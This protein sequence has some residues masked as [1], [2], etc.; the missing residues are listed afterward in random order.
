M[1]A[2]RSKLIQFLRDD[3]AV[4]TPAIDFALR[5]SP[6][7]TPLPM[8]LWQYGLITLSQLDQIFDWLEKA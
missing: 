6:L 5:Q 1:E 3:L 2:K 4:P 8:V 7:D